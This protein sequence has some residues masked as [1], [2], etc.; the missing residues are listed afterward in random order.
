VLEDLRCAPDDAPQ[1][2]VHH[3]GRGCPQ[4][5]RSCLVLPS[6]RRAAGLR[7]VLQALEERGDAAL[8][9]SR[10]LAELRDV[11]LPRLMSGEIQVRD[12]RCGMLAL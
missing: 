10:A 7:P 12:A 2:V 1:R 5:P 3:Q 11:L 8:A 6:R 9:E 4:P